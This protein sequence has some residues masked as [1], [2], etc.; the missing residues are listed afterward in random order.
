MGFWGH[1]RRFWGISHTALRVSCAHIW[2]ETASQGLRNIMNQT[3]G[4][5]ETPSYYVLRIRHPTGD[6]AGMALCGDRPRI[7]GNDAVLDHWW[8]FWDRVRVSIGVAVDVK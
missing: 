8:Q 4:R 6:A 1:M 3:E 5:D 2:L 7:L